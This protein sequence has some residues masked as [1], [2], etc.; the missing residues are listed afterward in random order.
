MQPILELTNIADFDFN[1][2]THGAN[3]TA[4]RKAY[5]VDF[6]NPHG[7]PVRVWIPLSQ[8][9]IEN[10]ILLVAEWLLE[11]RREG[12]GSM[13]KAG[14]KCLVGQA[15]KVEEAPSVA[16]AF[17]R[18]AFKSAVINKGFFTVEEEGEKHRTF[19]F[20]T[21]AKGQ[22]II[23]LMIGQNNITDYAWF[24]FVDGETIRFWKN[25]RSGWPQVTVTLPISHEAINE[26]FE[27]IKGNVE[28]AGL[29]YATY[30]KHCSRCNKVLTTPE[31]LERGLGAE[32]AGLKY[33]MKK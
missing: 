5:I 4:S 11:P 10:G 29:R 22:T 28:G 19:R 15:I 16:P 24:G 2:H 12:I 21:N 26:C 13:L 32:C 14:Y 23:G 1:E 8:S 20:K 6:E 25:A 30:Y 17:D 7:K 27:A 3:V 33:G 9:R 18:P 31:S